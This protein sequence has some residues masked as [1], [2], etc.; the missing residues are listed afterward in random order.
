MGIVFAIVFG[1]LLIILFISAIGSLFDFAK[2]SFLEWLF[3]SFWGLLSVITAFLSAMFFYA[4]VKSPKDIIEKDK[5]FKKLQ[6]S[7]TMNSEITN[8]LN[9]NENTIDLSKLDLEGLVKELAITINKPNP[10]FLKGWGNERLQ[11]DIERAALI[12]DY[13]MTMRAAGNEYIEFKADAI[14]SYEKIKK[15][16][17]TKLNYLNID[18]F[19]SQNE[20]ELLKESLEHEKKKQ[21]FEVDKMSLE[22]ER[23][24]AETERIRAETEAFKEKSKRDTERAN[25]LKE[26]VKYFKDLS[27]VLKAYV[28]TQLGSDNPVIPQNDME[29]QDAIR[30]TV[31]RKQIAE[32]RKIEAEATE[33]EE[34]N[35]FLKWKHEREKNKRI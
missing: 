11:L 15:I 12:K 4:S 26:A 10:I 13:I 35:E 29:M 25:L 17:E 9:V 18:L 8:N 30:E 14:L 7:I 32:A 6:N 2:G 22:M 23:V 21:K 3:N 33:S 27:P 1:V 24:K 34:M 16:T 31:K 20:L 5:G 19:R 28:T